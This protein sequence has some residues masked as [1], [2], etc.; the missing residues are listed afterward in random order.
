MIDYTVY[1]Y[2]RNIW[3]NNLSIELDCPS[4]TPQVAAPSKRRPWVAKAFA[5]EQQQQH[6]W[7]LGVRSS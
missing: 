7:N 6:N 5:R 3:I 4:F 1:I 2:I